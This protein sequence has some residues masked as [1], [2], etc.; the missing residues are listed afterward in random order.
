MGIRSPLGY[1]NRLIWGHIGGT[2]VQWR[3]PFSGKLCGAMLEF[4]PYTR[5]WTDNIHAFNERMLAGGLEAEL[6]FPA[7]VAPESRVDFKDELSREYYLAVEGHDVRGAYFLT[8]EHWVANRHRHQ[9]ANF[10]L[11]LSE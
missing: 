6:C 3:I 4:V 9:V 1:T 11:P 10:R 5:E 2:P 7:L 8:H